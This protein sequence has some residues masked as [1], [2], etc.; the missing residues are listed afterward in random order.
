MLNS[1]VFVCFVVL[2]FGGKTS[3]IHG[4]VHQ[5]Q[6]YKNKMKMTGETTPE[7]EDL[8]TRSHGG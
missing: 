2:L 1:M 5:L 6:R 8:E 4:N 7:L 3:N